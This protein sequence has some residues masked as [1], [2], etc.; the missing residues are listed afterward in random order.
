VTMQDVPYEGLMGQLGNPQQRIRFH[1]M[2]KLLVQ[3]AVI[4]CGEHALIRFT[5]RAPFFYS[6]VAFMDSCS[7]GLL[8]GSMYS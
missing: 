5:T 8:M 3:S 1:V 2:L 4:S 6:P 7:A